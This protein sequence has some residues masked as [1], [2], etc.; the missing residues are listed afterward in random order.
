MEE[1]SDMSIMEN[2]DDSTLNTNQRNQGKKLYS[3]EPDHTGYRYLVD[4]I[5]TKGKQ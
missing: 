4:E 3:V 5:R 2:D 1:L